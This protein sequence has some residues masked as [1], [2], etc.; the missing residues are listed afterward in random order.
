MIE[1]AF[2]RAWEKY[3]KNFFAFLLA[4]LVVFTVVVGSFLIPALPVVLAILS[5]KPF[6]FE[7]F[8][9]VLIIAIVVTFSV[10]SIMNFGFYFMLS[11][12]VKGQKPYVSDLF[13]GA[14]KFLTR[15]IVQAF[16]FF[17]IICVIL[18]PAVLTFLFISKLLG[19]LLLPLFLL[20]LVL[21]FFFLTFWI[22]CI[23]YYDVGVI[24]GMK[25]SC[26]KVRNNL[27]EVFLLFL[28]IF[29][30]NVVAGLVG[31]VIPLLPSIVIAPYIG[32][33]FLEACKMLK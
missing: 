10:A 31:L 3:R 19:F 5:G 4:S 9:P 6:A 8:I 21:T 33:V 22:P 7:L 25:L 1:A 12:A 30:I 15:A 18:S 27:L 17:A 11:R 14:G 26:G 2:E 24:E 23:V 13:S 16:L 29:F 32:L 20:V 28:G